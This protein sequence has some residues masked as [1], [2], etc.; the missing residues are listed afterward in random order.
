MADQLKLR[1]VIDGTSDSFSVYI[2]PSKDI[3]DLKDAIHKKKEN[4][5]TAL[6]IDADQ[7]ILW[8]IHNVSTQRKPLGLNSLN[9][10]EQVKTKDP[11]DDQDVPSFREPDQSWQISYVF[12]NT[13]PFPARTVQIII[14]LPQQDLA[15][16]DVLNLVPPGV[17]YSHRSDRDPSATATISVWR[18]TPTE[19]V[20][21]DDFLDM[22]NDYTPSNTPMY[23]RED[24]RFDE[25]CLVSDEETLYSALDRNIYNTLKRIAAPDGHFGGHSAVSMIGSPDRIFYLDPELLRLAIEV[26]TMHVLSTDDVVQKY[27]SDIVD[28]EEDFTSPQSTIYQVQQIF[29][30][31]SWNELQY[32]VLTTYEQTWFLQRDGK[33]LYVSPAI[34]YDN[35]DPTLF[36]C[37]ACIM[38]LAR[39]DHVNEPAS[40]SPP[41]GPPPD[42]PPHDDDSGDGDY[43][44]EDGDHFQNKRK[45]FKCRDGDFSQNK[46]KRGDRSSG[47]GNQGS[48]VMTRRLSTGFSVTIGEVYRSEFE[49]QDLLGEGR[50]GKV[51]Q[52]RW[53]GETVALKICD[54][55]QHPEYEEEVLTEVAVYDTLKP[56]QGLCIPHFKLAGYDGGI[57]VIGTEIAGSPL[58]VDELSYHDLLEIVDK[59]SLIHTFGILHNDIRPDNILIRRCDDGIKVCF[60]DFA[61]SKRSSDKSELINEIVKLEKLLGLHSTKGMCRAGLHLKKQPV[62]GQKRLESPEDIC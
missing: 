25:D 62:S 22:V 2:E 27:N 13:L 19:V 14:G 20:G 47:S 45:R 60:I 48:R 46:R 1:C 24:F 23:E 55:Y 57:F 35:E 34:N 6:G 21:W 11:D 31:L 8:P 43:D 38:R 42:S 9:P 30:Y 16:S 53:R 17:I 37:Y 36:Q 51:F 54:L 18:R 15:E 4:T 40:P 44:P 33:K 7:L 49:F 41:P 52:T 28:L 50:S 58:A 32:G 61:L 29:G 3:D 12:E 26:K 10:A 5:F 59:L 39:Q 56:L